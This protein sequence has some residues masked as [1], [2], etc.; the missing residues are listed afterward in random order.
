VLTIRNQ[1]MAAFEAARTQRII[2]ELVERFPAT[3]GAAFARLGP[4]GARD[5]VQDSV[6][7]CKDY[8]IAA[9]G[10]FERFVALAATHGIAFDLDPEH[11]WA[12]EILRDPAYGPH[13]KIEAVELE[14]FARAVAD[15]VR[16]RW[17]DVVASRG[18]KWTRDSII[19]A[20]DRCRGYGIVELPLVRRYVLLMHGVAFDLDE[21]LPG[22]RQL[23]SSS[24]VDPRSKMAQLEAIAL[25]EP[26]RGGVVR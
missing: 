14:F 5:L 2:D 18:M 13:E 12:A 9:R 6:H 3:N 4:D 11:L 10:L 8:G 25:R 17:P 22:A 20:R 15:E 21:S 24:D 1:Q 7:R 23:L 16:V 19:H 26:G